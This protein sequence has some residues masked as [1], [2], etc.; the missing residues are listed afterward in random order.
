MSWNLEVSRFRIVIVTAAADY[1]AHCGFFPS[2]ELALI[3]QEVEI[4][5]KFMKLRNKEKFI[6]EESCE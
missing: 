6:Y 5:V 1:F 4:T 2:N 3:L